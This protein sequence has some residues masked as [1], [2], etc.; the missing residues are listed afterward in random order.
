MTSSTTD[1]IERGGWVP[2]FRHA[3]PGIKQPDPVLK[4]TVTIPEIA[5]RVT[6]LALR[7]EKGQTRGYAAQ[8]EMNGKESCLL[9]EIGPLAG[10]DQTVKGNLV[11]RC[12]SRILGLGKVVIYT[13]LE[14]IGAGSKILQQIE[15]D[16]ANKSAQG[17]DAI[18]DEVLESVEHLPT[19]E[20]PTTPPPAAKK[21][22]FRNLFAFFRRLFGLKA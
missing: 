16:L 14:A 6:E 17:L 22:F 15:N 3:Q 21:S 10:D 20:K 7:L 12:V 19:Q 2:Q 8:I 13:E 1:V 5:D 4:A 11:T 9:V 18:A